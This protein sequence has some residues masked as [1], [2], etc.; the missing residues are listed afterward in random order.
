MEASLREGLNAEELTHG[1]L[2]FSAFSLPC[3][4]TL[5]AVRRL[6]NNLPLPTYDFLFEP[7]LIVMAINF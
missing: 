1:H 6:P 5:A 3:E 4:E 2:S 7:R